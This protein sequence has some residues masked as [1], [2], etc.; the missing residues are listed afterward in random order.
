VKNLLQK[1][2]PKFSDRENRIVSVG[3]MSI[4]QKRQDVLIEA[5]KI[6]NEKYPDLTLHFYGDGKDL[7]QVKK[8]AQ[9]SNLADKIFFHGHVKNVCQEIFNAKIFVLS[10]DY[11]GIPNALIESMLLGVPSISTDCRPG[12]ARI[13][14]KDGVNG[15]ISPKGDSRILSENIIR[16]LENNQLADSFTMQSP[17]ISET[18]SEANIAQKWNDVLKLFS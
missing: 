7:P 9:E 5:F 10:S 16:L 6:V 18:F 2:I 13:L 4:K 14:I 8:I 1:A 17:K 3:R 15:I 11:E 12:G